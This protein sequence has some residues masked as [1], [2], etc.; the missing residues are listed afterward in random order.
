[1]PK[2]KYIE[3]KRWTSDDVTFSMTPF[4]AKKSKK[5]GLLGEEKKSKT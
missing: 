3:P 1:M 5:L 4:C 2:K